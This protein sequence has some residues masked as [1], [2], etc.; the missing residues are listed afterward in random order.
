MLS[1]T[2]NKLERPTVHWTC[3]LCRWVVFQVLFKAWGGQAGVP[4][5]P[6]SSQPPSTIMR[7]ET[8][9][10]ALQATQTWQPMPNDFTP[11]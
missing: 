2:C 5:R 10:T 4:H 7:P 9:A 8:L 11:Y 1:M 3:F 6:A